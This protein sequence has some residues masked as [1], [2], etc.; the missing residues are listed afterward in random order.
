MAN[1][2]INAK[3]RQNL[4]V[5]WIILAGGACPAEKIVSLAK[6]NHNFTG[7]IVTQVTMI[8]HCLTKRGV[9]KRYGN[10][11]EIIA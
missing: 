11:F 3:H 7:C 6:N 10:I 9:L 1:A 8:L 4:L 2:K 5:K